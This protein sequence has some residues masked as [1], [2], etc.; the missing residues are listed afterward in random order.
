MKIINQYQNLMFPYLIIKIDMQENWN[1]IYKSC[2]RTFIRIS[3]SI[4]I[5]FKINID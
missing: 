4:L 3:I 5:L 2:S 1:N